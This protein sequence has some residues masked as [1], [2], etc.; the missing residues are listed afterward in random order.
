MARCTI[1]TLFRSHLPHPLTTNAT[2][3]LRVHNLTLLVFIP[4]TVVVT[5]SNRPT[6]K[7]W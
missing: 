5:V 1:K 2:I 6:C 4:E 3:K 7:N